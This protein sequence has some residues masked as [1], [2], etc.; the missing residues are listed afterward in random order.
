MCSF[1]FFF[2]FFLMIRRP[3][4]STLFP[5]T[6]LFRSLPGN[7]TGSPSRVRIRGTNSLSLNNE[8][9]YVVDG[10]RIVSANRSSSICDVGCAP[11]S[12]VND[13]NPEEI[14]SIDVVKGP[15]AAALYGTDAANGVVVIKTKR[16]RPGP[17]RWSVFAERGII[18]DN[19]DYPVAYR[20]WRT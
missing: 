11:P 3:P 14:E 10:V 18:T 16:G 7:Q 1:F 4:R 2:F 5:Y 12:R 15:S 9:V 8:P 17:S 6:T 13:L 20:G 19:N